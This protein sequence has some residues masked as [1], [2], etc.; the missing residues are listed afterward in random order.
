[1][2]VDG[3]WKVEAIEDTKLG[4]GGRQW[5]VNWGELNTLLPQTTRSGSWCAGMNIYFGTIQ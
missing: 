1:M 5:L 2:E 3:T 4:V